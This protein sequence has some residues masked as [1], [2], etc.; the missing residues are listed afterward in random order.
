MWRLIV[1]EMFSTCPHNRNTNEKICKADNMYGAGLTHQK[2]I[3][4]GKRDFNLKKKQR[5]LKRTQ[6]NLFLLSLC[7]LC[8]LLRPNFT[9]NFNNI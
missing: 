8:V 5:Q 7:N 2:L 4:P 6:K 3:L 1:Y 9:S